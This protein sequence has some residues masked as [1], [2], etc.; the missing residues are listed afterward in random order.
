LPLEKDIDGSLTPLVVALSAGLLAS[1]RDELLLIYKSG[2]AE[3]TAWAKLTIASPPAPKVAIDFARERGAQLVTQMNETTKKRLANVI[4]DGIKNKRGVPGISQ[5]IRK[6]FADMT[7]YRSE[8]IARTETANALTHAS[9][10]RMGDLGV[11]GKEWVTVGDD[12]VSL[13]CQSNEAQG[14]IPIDQEFTSGVMGP[15]QHPACRC[16]IAPVMLRK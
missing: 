2:E 9:L 1:V 7:R 12:R 3:M 13:E 6:T 15:P 10:D 8:L 14:V 4:S 16:A 5:D 11:D